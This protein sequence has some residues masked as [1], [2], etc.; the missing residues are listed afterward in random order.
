MAGEP[1]DLAPAV[2]RAIQILDAL[3]QADQPVKPADL[4]AALSL[5]KS[6]LHGVCSSLIAGGLVERTEKG[7]YML[8]LRIVDLANARL[9]RNNMANEFLDAWRAYP[10]FAQE[11]ALLSELDGTDVVYVVCR[12]S[13]HRLG[14]TFRVGMRLPAAFTASG[15]AL[16]ATLD[17]QEIERRYSEKG[18]LERLTDRSVRSVRALKAQLREVRE[19]GYSI[20]DGETREGM[21]SFGAVV[22]DRT[23]TR[24]V[25][26]IALC[27]FRGGAPSRKE[28][29]A[30][31][32]LKDIANRLSSKAAG[33]GTSAVGDSC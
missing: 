16:L 4:A 12:N 13:A 5:P 9:A 23:G 28:K 24:P 8:G 22:W 33:L 21:F 27:F 31:A 20:D 15:K 25:A 14:V 30:A 18:S 10:D 1:R 11:A 26:G 19:R 3:A 29:Q 2:T 7:E 32:A 17:D 6:S